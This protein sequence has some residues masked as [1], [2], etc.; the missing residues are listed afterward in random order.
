MLALAMAAG[1]AV[2]VS[3]SADPPA[4]RRAV[5]L[6]NGL[7]QIREQYESGFDEAATEIGFAATRFEIETDGERIDASLDDGVDLVVV[8]AVG[9]DT[10]GT[11]AEH[12]DT[13]FVAFDQ[14]V[15]GVNVTSVIINSHEG[16]YLAG[17]AAARTTRTGTVGV[18]GG[19]DEEL[20]WEFAAGFEAGVRATDPNIDIVTEY[21]AEIPNF[22][23]GYENAPAAEAA[24]RR[25]YAGGA[26]VIFAA[27]GTSGLGVFEAAADLTAETGIFRWAIGVDTDQYETVRALP[28]S[29]NP[30]RWTPH[31]LTSVLKHSDRVVQDVVAAFMRND[32]QRGI[33][34]V[35][36][37]GGAGGISYSGGFLDAHRDELER[38]RRQIVA[39]EIIVPCGPTDRLDA[40]SPERAHPC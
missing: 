30:G 10:A 9:F 16:S 14:V 37:S 17:V 23:E 26:D 13:V 28:L 8:P 5:L 36:L 38:V 4:P 6:Y 27:A 29:V 20:I 35:D 11:A 12:P 3:R 39:G 31:I 25:M 2:A 34:L 18:I 32:L 24:A 21:L 1:G 7:S 15:S 19:V 33:H 40:S 22:G